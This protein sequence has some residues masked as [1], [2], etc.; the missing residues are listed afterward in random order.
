VAALFTPAEVAKALRV[1]RR[2]VYDRI[3]SGD[4]SAVRVGR[5]PKPPLRIPASS[6]AALLSPAKRA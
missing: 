6:L 2:T 1:S 3:A 4:L 5:G